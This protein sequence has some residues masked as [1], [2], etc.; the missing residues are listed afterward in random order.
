MLEGAHGAHDGVSDQR[1]QQRWGSSCCAPAAGL[2]RR[3]SVPK[4]P[5][6]RVVPEAGPMLPEVPL[7]AQLPE[8][9]ARQGRRENRPLGPCTGTDHSG[10][11]LGAAGGRGR[12]GGLQCGQHLPLKPGR[13]EGK[14]VP[15]AGS[16]RLG[17]SA[18]LR[19]HH[20][21]RFSPLRVRPLQ[22]WAAALS[23]PYAPAR[24]AARSS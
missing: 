24:P 17:L 23:L 8:L 3:P 15:P 14:E 5:Q 7:K 1:V 22:A 9:L 19:L 11:H 18:H 20:S 6:G 10:R 21:P 4:R 13:E 16:A 2:P 12:A